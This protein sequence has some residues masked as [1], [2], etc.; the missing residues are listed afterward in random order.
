MASYFK[1]QAIKIARNCTKDN[2]NYNGLKKFQLKRYNLPL[3]IQYSNQRK[4]ISFTKSS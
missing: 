2:K 4:I 1:L 3:I